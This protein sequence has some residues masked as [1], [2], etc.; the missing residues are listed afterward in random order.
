MGSCDK[1]IQRYAIP[2]A[3]ADKP[4]CSQLMIKKSRFL[5]QS[6]NVATPADARAFIARIKSQNA[7]ATHNCWAFV[8]GAPCSATN[9][10]SSDDGEPHGTAGRP[11]LD[12]LQHSGIGQICTVVS[13]WF[14]GIKLGT[15]G[16]VRAYQECV[17][18]NLKT[19]AVAE[20]QEFSRWRLEIDYPKI[21]NLRRLLPML[22]SHLEK[23]NY[24]QSAEFV[25]SV[26]KDRIA[27]F[28]ASLQQLAPLALEELESVNS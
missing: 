25:I 17:R 8:A 4:H 23:E 27:E 20:K 14:G 5:A 9:I 12:V 26:P 18:E 16:L 3:T 19:L 1:S 10:A 11:M 7:S 21:D 2:L 13:R 24:E 6:C 15:G 22:E 28:M